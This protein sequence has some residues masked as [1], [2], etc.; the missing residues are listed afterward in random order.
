MIYTMA[1]RTE[2][3]ARSLSSF[4]F[5]S[6]DA[7]ISR[8]SCTDLTAFCLKERVDYLE[9]MMGDSADHHK[10]DTT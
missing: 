3:L 1:S 7:G 6:F 10:K 9:S 5:T 4:C 2:A 8:K